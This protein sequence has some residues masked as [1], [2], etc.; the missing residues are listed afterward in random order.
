MTSEVVT[1]RF[2]SSDAESLIDLWHEATR[3]IRVS[4]TT[5]RYDA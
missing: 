3:N 2:Q 5:R 1:R 4:I